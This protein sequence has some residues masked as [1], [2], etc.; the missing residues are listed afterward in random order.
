M[1][2]WRLC[3]CGTW[4]H[5]MV[6]DEHAAKCE[7]HQAA[8]QGQL[9]LLAEL[10]TPDHP[11]TKAKADGPHTSRKAAFANFPRVGNQRHRIL[12]AIAERDAGGTRGLTY[13]GMTQATG[14]AGVS[15]S[16]RCSEL[17]AG[18]W[19]EEDG[20]RKTRLKSEARVWVIT[21]KAR[22]ALGLG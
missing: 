18:G 5:P 9:D 6:W 16:A 19:I 17:A 3:E 15:T 22:K 14:I 12:L 4:V 20:E 10:H 11:L 7:A 1:T 13:D 21:D 2:N 8:A